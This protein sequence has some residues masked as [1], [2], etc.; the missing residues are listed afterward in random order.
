MSG[1]KQK[2]A[3]DLLERTRAALLGLAVGDALGVPVEFVSR[4]R[5]QAEPVTDMRGFGTHNQP[6][7]TWSDDTS[8]A[9]CLAKSLCEGFDLEDQANRFVAWL[10]RGSWTPH[11]EVFD[12]GRTTRVAI[13]QLR[14]VTDPRL[15]GPRD[16]YSNGNGSLM[17]IVPLALFFHKATTETRINAAMDASCLTHGHIR[18]QLACAFYVELAARLVNREP[19]VE[20]LPR[21]QSVFR[22][23]IERQYPAERLAFHPILERGIE[24]L[25][26]AE[27]ESSGYV[28]HTLL[29]SLWCCLTTNAYDEAVL[30]AVNLGDDTDTTGA[31]TGALAGLIYGIDAIPNQ[32]VRALARIDDVEELNQRFAEACARQ[33][34]VES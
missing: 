1:L 24:T 11:G 14:Q 32:W 25:D 3:T 29:A 4:D 34:G 13:A 10:D 15:A 2:M 20:A 19:I 16:Q 30:R 26:E 5:L 21:T 18:S 22:E 12:I 9:L 7:G 31:V 8:L 28:L 17:R 23:L 33:I 27:V 6:P